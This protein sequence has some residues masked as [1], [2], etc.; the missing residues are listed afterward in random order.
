MLTIVN[1]ARD[2]GVDVNIRANDAGVVSTA[3]WGQSL[4]FW[5]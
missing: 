4:R 3:V 1:D 5:R 2:D